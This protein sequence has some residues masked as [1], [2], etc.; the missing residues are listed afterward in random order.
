M[1]NKKNTYTEYFVTI[2]IVQQGLHLFLIGLLGVYDTRVGHAGHLA[3]TTAAAAAAC[4][5]R[6]YAWQAQ[7]SAAV[8]GQAVGSHLVHVE[9]FDAARRLDLHQVLQLSHAVVDDLVKGERDVRVYAEHFSQRVLVLHAVHVAVEEV[10][11]NVQ[12][13]RVVVVR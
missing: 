3:A 6:C 4:Y 7:T 13:R 1:D 10:A 12:E 9:L 8:E 5:A 2:L 11:D